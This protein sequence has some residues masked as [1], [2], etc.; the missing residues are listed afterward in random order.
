MKL[1]LCLSLFFVPKS[2]FSRYAVSAHLAS[3]ADALCT[4]HAITHGDAHEGNPLLGPHPTT[5]R[6]LGQTQTDAVILDMLTHVRAFRSH[7]RALRLAY[8]LT[9][10]AHASVAISSLR[11]RGLRR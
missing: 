9:T 7:P 10:T 6:L 11:F 5:A 1:I 3:I 8:V 2:A 4:R